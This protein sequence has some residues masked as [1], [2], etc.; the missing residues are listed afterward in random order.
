MHAPAA[1]ANG[2]GTSMH[3]ISMP[4][5]QGSSV[6]TKLTKQLDVTGGVIKSHFVGS[7]FSPLLL[8]LQ[9]FDHCSI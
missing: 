8:S 2:A 1:E 7:V 5:P 3:H 4:R 9:K 6:H